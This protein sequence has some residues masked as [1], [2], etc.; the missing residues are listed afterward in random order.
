[1][2]ELCPVCFESAELKN[3][4][5]DN[6][7]VIC[8]RCG[9]F[10][11]SGSLYAELKDCEKYSDERQRYIVS[12]LT[13]E[14]SYEGFALNTYNFKEFW[15]AKD[16]SVL[17]RIDRLLMYSEKLARHDDSLLCQLSIADLKLRAI[18]WSSNEIGCRQLLSIAVDDVQYLKKIDNNSYSITHKGW[19]RLTVLERPNSDSTQGFVAMPFCDELNACYTEAIEP[20]IK[21]AGYLP[22]RVDKKEHINKVDDE[23]ILHIR[24]SRFMVTD[25]TDERCNVYYE[26]GFAYGLR[27]PIFYTAREGTK[28]HFDI[29]QYNCIFWKD[30][31]LGNI[32]TALTRRIEAILGNGK[33]HG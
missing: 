26:A 4:S 17:D 2:H 24:R 8:P 12:S 30:D 23:I 15:S 31:N 10:L 33:N 20:A 22:F 27:L 7:H 1:M 9:D 19:E 6:T 32:K 16:I 13:R 14:N 3:G 25:L 18:T 29:Q 28:L 11:I 5:S 21:E